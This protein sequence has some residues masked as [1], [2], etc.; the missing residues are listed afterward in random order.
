VQQHADAAERHPGCEGGFAPPSLAGRDR[1]G[2]PQAADGRERPGQDDLVV[3]VGL[4]LDGRWIGRRAVR[5]EHG[6]SLYRERRQEHRKMPPAS[7]QVTPPP[8][9]LR[10]GTGPIAARPVMEWGYRGGR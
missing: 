8:G 3:Q 9:S 4:L 7:H 2:D 10:R 1:H 6:P 5:A